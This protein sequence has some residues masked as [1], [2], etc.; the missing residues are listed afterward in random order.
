[1]NFQNVIKQNWLKSSVGAGLTTLC[2]LLLWWGRPVGEAWT[3]ASY[4]YL[5]RFISQRVKDQVALIVLDKDS[6][7]M[8]GQSRTSLWDRRLHAQLLERLT[9]EQAKLVVFDINFRDSMDAQTDDALAGAIRRNGRVILMADL[10]ERR[11]DGGRLIGYSTLPPEKKFIEAAA[12]W[13]VGRCSAREG[14]IPRTHWPHGEDF[15]STNLA[16]AAAFALEPSLPNSQQN[17]WLRYYSEDGPWTKTSYFRALASVPAGYFSNKVVFVGSW[18][19]DLDPTKIH[20][21]K[22]STPYTRWNDEA[23]GG[24]AIMATTFLNLI[25]GDWLRRMPAAV[26]MLLLLFTGIGIGGTLVLLRPA[27]GFAAGLGVVVLTFFFFIPLSHVTNFWFPW[28][29]IAGGQV[30]CALVCT[31]L[32][33]QPAKARVAERYPGYETYGDPL[34]EGAYGKVWLVRDRVDIWYA[35]KEIERKRFNDPGPYDREFNGIKNYKPVSTQHPGLLRV[36]FVYR[37]DDLGYF[38]YV[39][40]LGDPIDPDWLQ[41]GAL[42]QSLDLDIKYKTAPQ[43]RLPVRECI[44]IGMVLA[45]A[46]DFLHR[47]G[48]THRDI[49][50]SNIVFVKGQPKLAD[51]G[52]VSRIRVD[53]R[54][55]TLIGTEGYMPPYDPP[56]TVPADIFAL[57]KVLYVI[58]TGKNA[59]SFSALPTNLVE[60]PEFMK[61]N[62]IICKA[63]H[64][65]RSQRYGSAGELLEDLRKA[66]EFLEEQTTRVL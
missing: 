20:Q 12:G 5:F 7:E 14:G 64:P 40:E 52:L 63:C 55:N 2:G 45:D 54:E 33:W 23:V 60:R 50:P 44:S 17:E 30:P 16:R 65:E 49:K 1:M 29:I 18:P 66:G 37:N 11:D 3:N 24:V 28:L 48:L 26:E 36:E 51:I 34:G 9:R 56:G 35:M 8:L 39:M 57:G 61:L 62:E 27:I 41:R 6:Y 43:G 10:N 42:Y 32:A 31:V 58:S 19:E 53:D 46:L 59:K 4:D 13:G 38:I 15:N 22:F 25:Q 47:N 21:D